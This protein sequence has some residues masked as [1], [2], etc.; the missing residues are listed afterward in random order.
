MKKRLKVV[1]TLV[2]S[3]A[4]SFSLF[5]NGLNLNSVGTK[6]ATMGGA[7]IGLAND[8][9]AVFWNPAG[10]TQMK[11][12]NFAVYGSFIMP[13]GTYQFPQLGID[14]QTVSNTYPSGALGYFKPL[15]E[16]LV[17]GFLVY[18]P[19]G[20][21]AEWNGDDLALL[22]NG[23]SL[24]WKSMIG[25][26]TFSPAVAYKI[27]DM[28]SV[29]ATL[30]FD[31]G[32]LDF[33]MPGVGQYSENLTGNGI[34]ATLG[35]MIKPSDKVSLGLSYKTPVKISAE[36]EAKMEGAP[37]LSALVNTTLAATAT[38]TREITW[39][40]WFGAGIAVK[41]MD[42]L[43]VTADI[44]YT[45]WKKL[46]E[47]EV[48]FDNQFWNYLFSSEYKFELNWSDT[49][50]YRFGFEY[51]LSDSLAIRGGFYYDPS[52]ASEDSLNILL[53]ELT[54]NAVTIGLGYKSGNLRI[55]FGFEYLMGK[56]AECPLSSETG[57]PG[58]HSMNI[59][60]PNFAIS[61]YF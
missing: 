26:V 35:L 23:Q 17:V 2:M 12:Q 42:N 3:L 60:A 30:N 29:G 37:L 25:M 5:S 40:M 46:D 21:G 53:P 43:T 41:P 48:N 16:N 33:N 47:I 7:F 4:F 39:P 24:E 49:I 36:G 13:K 38:A 28:I 50:Q 32:M 54:Y 9:S 51:G 61:Y 10:L 19:A 44:Q 55:D 1:F 11:D 34:G 56:D 6:A 57:M 22:A 27:N 8:Y 52:P 18:V 20:S 45:N 31:Y 15:S 59:M 14:T 58:T